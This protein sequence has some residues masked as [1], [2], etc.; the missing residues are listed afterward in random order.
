MSNDV[1][2]AAARWRKLAAEMLEA[3]QEMTDPEARAVMLDIA[4][5]YGKLARYSEARLD[6]EEPKKSE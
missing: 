6:K 3:A 5:R 2:P 1:E 4:E